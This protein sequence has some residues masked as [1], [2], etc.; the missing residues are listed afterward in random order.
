M[1]LQNNDI[2]HLP[3]NA[4]IVLDITRVKPYSTKELCY[5]YAISNKTFNKWINSFTRELGTRNGRFY[6]VKQVE[7][8]FMKLGLP[9]RIKEGG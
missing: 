7:L 1:P 9:Y 5:M 6:T 8:I 2:A 3:A 4:S